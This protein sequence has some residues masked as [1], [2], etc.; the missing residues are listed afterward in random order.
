MESRILCPLA[1]LGKGGGQQANSENLWPPPI[2]NLPNKSIGE[3]E[4]CSPQMRSSG[5]VMLVKE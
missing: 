4:E 2:K 1:F 3:I 5:R